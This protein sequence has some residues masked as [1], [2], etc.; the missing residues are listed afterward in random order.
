MAVPRPTELRIRTPNDFDSE[1]TQT[2]RFV[3]ELTLYFGMNGSV[4]DTDEKKIA[5]ALSYMNGGQAGPWKE[6]KVAEFATAYPT[7]TNFVVQLKEA[8]SA[9][10]APGDARAK[11]KT[12][13]QTGTADEYIS[14]F[15][16][17]IAASEI[18]GD[19]ARIDYFIDG[20]MPKLVERIYGMEN[21]PTTINNWYSF[22]SRFD[23]QWCR[24]KAIVNRSHDI[25]KPAYQPR[26]NQQPRYTN[27]R[28]PN[29]MDIDRLNQTERTEH[30]RK[31]LCFECHQT[32]HR[33]SECQQKR[34]GNQGTS[35][36][37]P[38]RWQPRQDHRK[39]GK[40]TYAKIKAMMGEL[41]NEE[42]EVAMKEL[43]EGG[44]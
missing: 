44:F 6:M 17:L 42:R 39:T 25:R 15:K 20:L 16:T 27:T 9:A 21:V 34:Y 24:G 26:G 33:A 18:T 43:E 13:R 3:T 2:N 31:G 11:L 23:N 35:Q 40:D 30:M 28:D 8:F 29:A 38:N 14:Q 12:L 36:N 5:F 37:Q 41:D 4:Y 32:G 22:A 10:D 19:T 7:Y 1:R